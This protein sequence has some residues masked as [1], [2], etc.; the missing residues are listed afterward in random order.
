LCRF[1]RYARGFSGSFDG[2]IKVWNWRRVEDNDLLRTLSGHS[3]GV[4]AV[5]IAPD[6]QTLI[7]G[8]QDNTIKIWNLE[9]GELRRTLTAHSGRV[10]SL[11]VSADGEILVSGASDETVKV[12]E[13]STGQLINTLTGIKSPAVD[14]GEDGT[15]LVSGS[16]S[17]VLANEEVVVQVWKPQSE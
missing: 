6:G 15:T 10:D 12:W 2:T 14:I 13:L 9:T 8:G 11:A 17:P 1:I 16:G 5:A 7:S 4:H 3:G